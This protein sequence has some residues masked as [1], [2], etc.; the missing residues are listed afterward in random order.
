MKGLMR[1]LVRIMSFMKDNE[2][3]KGGALNNSEGCLLV[4]V[5]AA[6]SQPS[7][8]CFSESYGPLHPPYLPLPSF[9]MRHKTWKHH[10][11]THKALASVTAAPLQNFLMH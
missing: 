2:R 7:C 11:S 6:L 3:R 4:L 10:Q 8:G 1:L 5:N 9:P